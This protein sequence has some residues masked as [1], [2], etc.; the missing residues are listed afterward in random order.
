MSYLYRIITMKLSVLIMVCLFGCS[1]KAEPDVYKLTQTTHSKEVKSKATKP[2]A[3]IK[4]ISPSLIS[5]SPNQQVH[6][7]IILETKVA[8][9]ELLIDIS[10]SDGLDLLD[11][12]IQKSIKVISSVPIKTPITLLAI[13]NGR[14]YLN[15]H[16]QLNNGDSISTRSLTVIIQVGPPANKAIQLKKTAGENV[17]SLPVQETISNP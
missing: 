13:N 14:Y 5:V 2:G 7:D 4:L 1:G 17:I 10:K 15:M 16:V 12:P 8:S 11:T 6:V 9:G 3:A